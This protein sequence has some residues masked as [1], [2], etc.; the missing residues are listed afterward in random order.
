MSTNTLPSKLAETPHINKSFGNIHDLRR[1]CRNLILEITKRSHVVRRRFVASLNDQEKSRQRDLSEKPQKPISLDLFLKM[2]SL[3]KDIP[4][5]TERVRSVGNLEF[6]K[7]I[8][9]ITT[10]SEGV[11]VD[12]WRDYEVSILEKE[13][14][15]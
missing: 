11:I 1:T 5:F 13:F 2:V 14:S 4:E 6:T 8:Q 10:S 7:F 3:A 15:S 9:T 12:E